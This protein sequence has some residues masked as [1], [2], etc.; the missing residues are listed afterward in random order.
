MKI[1]RIKKQYS[2]EKRNTEDQRYTWQHDNKQTG[3]FKHYQNFLDRNS[4]QRNDK[5]WKHSDLQRILNQGSEEIPEI[6][7]E[8]IINALEDMKSNSAPGEKNW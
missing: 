8:E 1:Q 3:N 2:R 6:N 7:M 5:R 4:A